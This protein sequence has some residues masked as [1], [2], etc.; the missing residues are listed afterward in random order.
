MINKVINL[1]WWN[2]ATGHHR[3]VTTLLQTDTG[4]QNLS[5]GRP[6]DSWRY[7]MLWHL[8]VMSAPGYNEQTCCLFFQHQ[9]KRSAWKKLKGC[10]APLLTTG[11]F[12]FCFIILWFAVLYKQ[13]STAMQIAVAKCASINISKWKIFL[14]KRAA[15]LC[16]F[17]GQ[18]LASLKEL[19]LTHYDIWLLEEGKSPT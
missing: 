7:I 1:C 10:S 16:I 6:L 19:I 17:L 9:N 11:M 18:A 14:V 13:N 2:M 5:T 12:M 4:W 3:G 15:I 8:S